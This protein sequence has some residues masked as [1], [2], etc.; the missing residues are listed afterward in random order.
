MRIVFVFLMTIVISWG[1]V[2]DVLDSNISDKLNSSYSVNWQDIDKD[3]QKFIIKNEQ[4]IIDDIIS[5]IDKPIMDANNSDNGELPKI[6]LTRYDY[7]ILFI[8]MK[9]LIYQDKQ[10]RVVKIYT[11]VIQGL[12]KL[13]DKSFITLIFRMVIQNF[14]LKSL[15]YNI[16]YL[17][18][19]SIE[20]IYHKTPNL[21]NLREDDFQNSLIEHFNSNYS[22]R[23]YKKALLEL[24]DNNITNQ[25]L[26]YSDKLVKI[27]CDDMSKV[28]TKIDA[29][30]I[31]QKYKLQK[32]KLLSK[33]A[34]D[35]SYIFYIIN[36]NS[37]EKLDYAKYNLSK[38]KDITTQQ[39]NIE[40]LSKFLLS[41]NMPRVAFTK[42]DLLD[43]MKQNREV[44]GL[45]KDNIVS[46]LGKIID[47]Q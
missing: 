6:I 15:K 31:E 30:L 27:Y 35:I 41:N 42:L 8:Y 7:R 34:K 19:N 14:T 12:N 36:K 29:E 23:E 33:Y 17:D 9:Y 21:F 37:D 24:F 13:D 39:L 28:Y 10:D 43:A 44:I 32:E 4:S 46:S 26:L 45:L 16:P 2:F 20:Y 25:I 5:N 40:V 1:V 11:K 47:K 22:K 3:L 38:P 18:K